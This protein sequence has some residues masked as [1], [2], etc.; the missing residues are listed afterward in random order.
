MGGSLDCKSLFLAAA[1]L[2]GCGNASSDIEQRL[3][4]KARHLQEADFAVRKNLADPQANAEL[5]RIMAKSQ[6][7]MAAKSERIKNG[8]SYADLDKDTGE[9]LAQLKENGSRTRLLIEEMTSVMI[10]LNAYIASVSDACG[11][12]TDRIA[13]VIARKEF[14][15]MQGEGGANIE[16]KFW[17]VKW[18]YDSELEESSAQ[19]NCKKLLPL[20]EQYVSSMEE[21]LGEFEAGRR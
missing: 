7:N 8:Q 5:K 3:A 11:S 16:E 18:E 12:G 17:N 1:L 9:L 2:S 14:Q 15:K 13:K 10:D 6:A 4:D 21:K 19:L 20:F